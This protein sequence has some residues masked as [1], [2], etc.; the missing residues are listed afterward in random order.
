MF[1]V[2]WAPIM[3]MVSILLEVTEDPR[4]VALCLEGFK[5]AIRISSIFFLETQRDTFVTSLTKFT[6]LNNLKEMRPKNVEAIKTLIHVAHTEANF[7]MDSWRLILRSISQLERL[8]LLGSGVRADGVTTERVARKDPKKRG[9]RRRGPHDATDIEQ[10][11]SYAR[12]L[13]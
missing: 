6:Y 1:E 3:A 11:N 5:C 8:Q 7:L 12:V 13:C 9:S 4:V 2:V 10:I